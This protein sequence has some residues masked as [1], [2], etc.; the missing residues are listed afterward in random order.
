[1][2]YLPTWFWEESILDTS[3]TLSVVVYRG[4]VCADTANKTE[5]WNKNQWWLMKDQPSPN[6]SIGMVNEIFFL[7]CQ[8]RLLEDSGPSW[9]PYLYQ[10]GWA[11]LSGCGGW[12]GPPTPELFK[13]QCHSQRWDGLR[14]QTIVAN[15]LQ[16]AKTPIV[17]LSPSSPVPVYSAAWTCFARL[18]VRGLPVPSVGPTLLVANSGT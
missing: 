11:R 7:F 18:G 6:L 1:M 3:A 2:W 5:N 13:K 15:G 14:K 4:I 17:L 10:V 9:L 8:W 16:N 12:T